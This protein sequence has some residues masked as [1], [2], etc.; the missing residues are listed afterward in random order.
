M[1]SRA[2]ANLHSLERSH[3][4]PPASTTELSPASVLHVAWAGG[5][6]GIERLVADL[7]Q[8]QSAGGLEVGVALGRP[9]GPFVDSMRAAGI[10]ILDLAIRSGYDIEPR[11]LARAAGRLRSWDVIHLHAFNLPLGLAVARAGRP[12]VLTDHGSKPTGG[13]HA[14]PEALKRRLLGSFL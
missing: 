7:A 11:R 4:M 1:L 10:Q 3:S 13:R 14:F 2:G 8:E 6:G 9:R 12:T 5:F